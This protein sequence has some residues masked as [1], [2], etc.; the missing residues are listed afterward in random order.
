MLLSARDGLSNVVNVRSY[1]RVA[2]TG[3]SASIP[4]Q[5]VA[6][7]QGKPPGGAAKD[8]LRTWCDHGLYVSGYEDDL[9]KLA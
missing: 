2:G 8:M 3:V 5:A 4:S 7:K 1:K 6:D 9:G